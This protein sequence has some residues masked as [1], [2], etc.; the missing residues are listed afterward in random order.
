MLDN[1]STESS[2]QACPY[3]GASITLIVEPEE[4]AQTYV[5][6]CEV[7]CRPMVVNLSPEGGVELFRED[8]G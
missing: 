2:K 8:D 1:M 6:D 3:C 4:E 5:E 7:C